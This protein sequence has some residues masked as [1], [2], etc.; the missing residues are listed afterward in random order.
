MVNTV[1]SKLMNAFL[2]EVLEVID[3]S[4]LH[5]G[6]AGARDG[7]HFRVVLVSGAF[8]GKNPVQRQRMVYALFQEEFKRGIHAL[9]ISIFTPAEFAHKA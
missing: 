3:D 8:E 4:H 7:G 2:P 5:V 1:K 9:S 6:H